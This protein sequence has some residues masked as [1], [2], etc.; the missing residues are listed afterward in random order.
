MKR[1]AFV[2]TIPFDW[3]GS[4]ELWA[5]TAG[6][7]L[8]QGNS[9]H[10]FK[11]IQNHRHPR[12]E[13]VL[14]QGGQLMSPNGYRLPLTHRIWNKLRSPQQRMSGVRFHA[15]RLVRLK[16]DL[17]VISQGWNWDGM[18]WALACQRAGLPYALISHQANL[19]GWPEDGIVSKVA[20]IHQRAM[21]TFYVARRVRERT[22]EM[23][24][25][26]IPHAEI[27]RNPYNV[28]LDQALPWPDS[29]KTY[30]LA[31]VGRLEFKDK[32]QDLLVRVMGRAK[33]KQR[34]VKVSFYGSGINREGLE[35]LIRFCQADN[36]Q[37]A[38]QTD[39][40]EGIWRD[41]HALVLPSREEG[42]PL[43]VVEAML[44]GRPTIVTDIA[45]NA[46]FLQDGKNGFVCPS[47]CADLLDETLERAWQAR[48]EWPAMGLAAAK[49]IRAH[50]PE[51][52]GQVF[53]L[54]LQTLL[55]EAQ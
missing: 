52:A 38:G 31:S 27:V 9:I 44:C 8:A 46:E 12:M 33:W 22:E 1:I 39:D 45:G 24:G 16:P 23:I 28:S 10:I 5:A 13:R 18:D 20:E 37:L 36:C 40:V 3:G 26:R 14:R 6:H 2:S 25:E 4:E 15:Q 47:P 34:P 48:Q 32:G 42:L 53:A 55:G 11:E 21:A 41:H 54:R 50:V 43:V 19:R 51:D 17:T 29:E 49:D 35:R 30:R 7:L